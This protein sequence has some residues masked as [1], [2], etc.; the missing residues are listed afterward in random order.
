[1]VNHIVTY[2][3]GG[4]EKQ[5]IIP[6]PEFDIGAAMDAAYKKLGDGA[7]VVACKAQEA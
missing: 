6:L 3:E 7:E 2:R 4:K 1:M 5:V